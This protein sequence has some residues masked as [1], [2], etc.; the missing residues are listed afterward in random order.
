MQL[1]AGLLNSI[2]SAAR[3]PDFCKATVSAVLSIRIENIGHYQL[4]PCQWTNEALLPFSKHV[5]P[6][7]SIDREVVRERERY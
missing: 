6:R 2:R 3:A 7:T 4:C 5:C 1:M